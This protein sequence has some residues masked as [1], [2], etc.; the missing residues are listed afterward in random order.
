MLRLL[1][2]WIQLSL[3]LTVV[4]GEW[5]NNQFIQ[6]SVWCGHGICSGYFLTSFHIGLVAGAGWGPWHWRRGGLAEEFLTVAGGWGLQH[7]RCPAAV[8]QCADVLQC[9]H[10]PPALWRQLG[11]SPGPA[12]AAAKK[13]TV[14]VRRA[15][16][17]TTNT[18]E[19][20]H[21]KCYTTENFMATKR[22]S[23]FCGNISTFLC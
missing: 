18:H 9:D 16:G 15:A 12:A 17:L 7:N 8:L 20:S 4:G 3:G 6:L 11:G 1:L 13:S 21:Q 2:K 14:T 23:L 10:C 19:T 22:T 5:C